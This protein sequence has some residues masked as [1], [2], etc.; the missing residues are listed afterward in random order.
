MKLLKSIAGLLSIFLFVSYMFFVPCGMCG[1]PPETEKPRLLFF[2]SYSCHECSVIK[3]ELLPGVLEKYGDKIEIEMLQ[4]GDLENYK[5][6]IGLKDRY[7]FSGTGTP[8]IIFLNGEF[9]EGEAPIRNGLVSL[10][11]K[12]LKQQQGMIH[13]PGSID[14]TARFLSFS[15]FAVLSA[16]LIDG[17]NPCAFTV[18]VFFVSF[19]SVQGYKRKKLI[20][21]GGSFI[22]AVFLTYVLI[23][24]GLFN[25]LYSLGKFWIF[26]KV[27]NI[28]I[29][30]FSIVLGGLA[31][32]DFL[33]Y[34]KSHSTDDLVLKL[35]EK[36]KH[37]IHSIVGKYYRRRTQAQGTC[38]GNMC[39]LIF[40]ALSTGVLISVLESV[41]TGQ[42]YLP[43]I[44]LV[45]K[46]TGMN[47]RALAYLL[48]YNIMFVVPLCV[49]F[50]FALM[51]STSED[52]SCFLKKHMLMV[53]MLMVVLFFGLGAYLI[54]RA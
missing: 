20:F 45:L 11:E 39:Q 23:G 37:K 3:N 26:R 41:C 52:F 54:W 10:I 48:A 19:L 50:A 47:M 5:L 36:V 8:P 29:G 38:A 49:I 24:L 13:E 6:L 46:T 16:G 21:I 44:T 53:K 18:M 15:L 34:R 35:P 7:G 43:T 4:T 9:L 25:F 33:K 27:F 2:Y 28:T 40:A 30:I 51:G 14:L 12:S 17:I 1:Q 42:V 22:A 32:Y 31:V